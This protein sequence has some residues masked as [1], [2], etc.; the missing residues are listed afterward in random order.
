[1]IDELHER[2]RALGW[3]DVRPS[4]G[5]HLLALRDAPLTTTELASR[6][7][8]SK[9]AVSK[10]ADAM[11]D[12]ALLERRPHESDGRQSLLALAPRGHELLADVE[13]IYAELEREWA[14]IIGAAA[15]GQTKTRLANVLA[16][17]HG[18]ALPPI[19]PPA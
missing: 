15:L 4:F 16:T 18:G 5:F 19:R 10:L 14:D 8:V 17:V 2:L 9:Q 13:K 1:M 11:V 12:Q 3:E 7:G 6:L